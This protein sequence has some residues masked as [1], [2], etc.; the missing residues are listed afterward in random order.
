MRLTFVAW[1]FGRL[2]SAMFSWAIWI[3]GRGIAKDRIVKDRAEELKV[4]DVAVSRLTLREAHEANP[5]V[6]ASTAARP[7]VRSHWRPAPAGREVGQ[8][9]S[10]DRDEKRCCM[11]SGL[12]VILGPLPYL[13]RG[14][15]ACHGP[16]LWHSAP[17]RAPDT[18]IQ[19][20]IPAIP[21][22]LT[23]FP[24]DSVPDRSLASTRLS[25]GIPL[26]ISNA[27]PAL[28]RGCWAE[29]RPCGQPS[30]P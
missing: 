17:P 7:P 16:R 25:H 3:A 6:T 15:R 2:A 10:L 28:Q 20:T 26:T 14:R 21:F 9:S 18:A 8:R 30:D 19:G 27:D 24:A 1:V 12:F 22:S 23:G 11:V 13:S 4:P 5:S 29:R